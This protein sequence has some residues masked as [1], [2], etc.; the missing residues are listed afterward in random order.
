MVNLPKIDQVLGTLQHALPAIEAIDS[1]RK[2]LRKELPHILKANLWEQIKNGGVLILKPPGAE[3]PPVYATID[4]YKMLDPNEPAMAPLLRNNI[5]DLLNISHRLHGDYKASIAAM[6]PENRTV[7]ARTFGRCVNSGNR[8]FSE[9]ENIR[10]FLSPVT[11]STLRN[12]GLHEHCPIRI[13]SMLDDFGVSF[14][15]KPFETRRFPIPPEFHNQLGAL[16]DITV[17]EAA[18]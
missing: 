9:A 18:A 12:W 8:I 2:I 1:L 15:R 13:H 17:A 4:G 5:H 3:V 10:R 11:I 6:T 16:P 14:G 7:T